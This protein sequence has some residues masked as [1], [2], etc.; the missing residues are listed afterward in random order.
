M[1]LKNIILRTAELGPVKWEDVDKLQPGSGFFALFVSYR[2]EQRVEQEEVKE[3]LV[4]TYIV[5]PFT[6]MPSKDNIVNYIVEEEYG[7][8]YTEEEYDSVYNEVTNLIG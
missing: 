7:K 4:G 6:E 8:D 1:T 2:T 3:Y 5:L